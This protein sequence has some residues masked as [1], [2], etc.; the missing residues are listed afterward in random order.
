[1]SSIER[2]RELIKRHQ[3]DAA[4]HIERL[5]AKIEL[6][7]GREDVWVCD[8]DN[9]D[10]VECWSHSDVSY[11]CLDTLNCI[12]FSSSGLR[13]VAL[14]GELGKVKGADLDR[15]EELYFEDLIECWKKGGV[16]RSI[17][18]ERYDAEFLNRVFKS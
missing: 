9:K 1:M 5:K 6:K 18:S 4:E 11:L 14:V 3:Q 10:I 17:V 16:T 15:L 8:E 13:V 12:D 7:D 2:V